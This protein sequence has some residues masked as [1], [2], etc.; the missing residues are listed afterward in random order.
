MDPVIIFIQI[1]TLRFRIYNLHNDGLIIKYYQYYYY[2]STM[3]HLEY[4]NGKS[5]I[6]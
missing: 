6:W 1:Y 4:K 3:E 5:K 2:Q